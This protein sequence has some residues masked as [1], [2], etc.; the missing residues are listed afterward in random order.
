MRIPPWRTLLPQTALLYATA[1]ACWGMSVDLQPS[2]PSPAPLGTMATWTA[3]VSDAPPGTLIYRFRVANPGE[4]FHMVL[5][6]GPKSSMQWT[7]HD[8]E[9]TYQVE[10]S[11]FNLDTHDTAVAYQ[12]FDMAPIA[13]GTDAVITPTD[14]PLVFLYSAPPCEEGGTMRVVFSGSDNVSTATP[15]QNCQPGV[16]MN[17]YLAGL[18]AGETY[19]A[20]HVTTLQSGAIQRGPVLQV[21][22]G[23]LPSNV[24]AATPQTAAPSTRLDILL[25]ANLFSPTE[26][27]DL[28][29]NTLWYY[30]GDIS[31]L[32]RPGPGGTFW[33]VLEA[34]G[35][36][37]SHQVIREFDLAGMTLRETNAA[38]VS[39]LLVDMG[40]RPISSFHHEA[41]LLP[42]GKILVLAGVE[43]ILTGVQ[44]PGPVDVLG[45]MIIVLDSN[46]QVVWA[47]DTFDHLDP[48]RMATINDM[49]NVQNCEPVFQQ[50]PGVMATDWTHGNSVQR[51]PDGNLLYSS[52]SQDWVI[53]ID[54]QD[55]AGSGNILWRL[56]KDG[57]IAL[58]GGNS[59]SWFS[60]Q[61]DPQIL[62]DGVTLVLFDNSNLRNLSDASANSRGQVYKIDEAARTAT[63]VNNFDLGYFS[64]A[65][66]AA[67]RL[68]N[69]H[70]HFDVGFVMDGTSYSI[71][72]DATG[73][74]VYSLHNDAPVYRSFRMTDLYTPAEP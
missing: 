55:G 14:H 41:R 2:I 74:I 29:G 18:R 46:L 43:Q 73:K 3:T 26:A 7:L 37:Q 56:G 17:F 33:G 25:N 28:N 44:G 20:H 62:S 70:Y 48:A 13:T 31:F 63:L 60:H 69:G 71:E 45:D 16:T 5:D 58:S 65:L 64:F 4:D 23:D 34:T 8:H 9:G 49:C 36:D 54:Y 47:W 11:V 21:V 32:T 1:S 42:D 24:V 39:Q 6:Y 10:V 12:S 66:G 27:V 22:A 53:K 50:L 61:H 30:P 40:R 38:R 59:D 68:P 15:Q 67:Q 52:R 51:T 57:D 19:N 72:V 35:Q